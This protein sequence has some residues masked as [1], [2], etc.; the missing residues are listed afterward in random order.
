[1]MNALWLVPILPVVAFV[2]FIVGVIC[3]KYF[4]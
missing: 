3:D 2:G 1:M 4:Y